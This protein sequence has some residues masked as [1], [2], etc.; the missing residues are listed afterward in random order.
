MADFIKSL[1]NS[2]CPYDHLKIWPTSNNTS[3]NVRKS[4]PDLMKLVEYFNCVY[5]H[6]VKFSE[7]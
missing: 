4:N 5:T 6:E 7:K 2:H 1:K 3:L